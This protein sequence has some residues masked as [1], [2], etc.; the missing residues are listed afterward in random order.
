MYTLLGSIALLI[1][2]YI[3]Y[4]KFIE[5][6]FIVN[7]AT[8]TP[9][10]T[11]ADNLDYMPMPAWK[12]WTIQLLNIAGLGPIYGAIAGA[13]YGPVAMIWIVF[14]CI[15]A[16]AVHDYFAGML[17]LRH[18]GA[19]FPALVQR[20]L[21]KV[22]RV[23]TDIVSVVLMVLV[24]AAFTAGPAAVL[25]SK[26]GITFMTA[27]IAIFI[28]FLLAAI[29]PIN[30]I[31]GRIYPIFGAVL[32]VMAGAVLVAL[33][34]SGIAIPEVSLTNMHPN[35]LPVWPLLMVTISCGAISGF[36]STQSPII[37]RTIKK[38]SE[39]RKVFFGAMIG[40]GVIALIWCAAGMSFY[41]GTEGLLP[42]IAEIGAG[43]VVDEIS[44][45]LL[46]TFG[47]ILAILGIVIL[48]ITTGDTSLRSARM[49]VLDFLGSRL[50]KSS[51]ATAILATVAVAA[52]AFFLSTIDYQFL[53]RYVGM[54]N[55]MVATVMLWVA[56]SYLLKTGKFHW[57]AGL[58]ALFMTSVV[59]VYLMVA[60]EGFALAYDTGVII[61]LSFTVLVAFIYIYQ[62]F[63]HKAFTNPVFLT[64]K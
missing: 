14:G 62:I 7:D 44:Y 46:G 18:G 41:G 56:A 21:G 55:Q 29:L 30:Q 42:K 23:F 12:G 49:I 9:A 50:P 28:Y 40:E 34:T 39:G 63:K 16:G 25:S 36:H 1:V 45:A 54:T 43:G 10:Y 32:I 26:L 58:P 57:I 48:P 33:V 64:E 53:W 2:G 5:K 27:L 3:V 47:S 17:S 35:D 15:F 51:S 22:M 59:F 38:E 52:P 37:S 20:Y 24:A 61:G 19:Q 8:P 60:P 31:I 4:G 13:L 11:K 6:V